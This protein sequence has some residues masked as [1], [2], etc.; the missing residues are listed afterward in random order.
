MK[1]IICA[2][3]GSCILFMTGCNDWLEVAPKNRLDEKEMFS[4]EAGFKNALTGIYIGLKNDKLYGKN[5]SMD[6]VEYLA[7]HWEASPESLSGYI[8]DYDYD[9][10][11]VARE[12]RA[13]YEKFY[14]VIVNINN[15][16]KYIDNGVLSPDM[17][18]LIKGEAL[19]LR[20]FCHLDLLRLFG[21]VPAE[22]TEAKILAYARIVSRENQLPNTW[23]EYVGFLVKD[24]NEAEALLKG[25]DMKGMED[26]FYSYRE[27]RMN[28]WAVLAL[29]ARYYM[30]VGDKKNAGKYAGLIIED[31]KFRLNSGQDFATGGKIAYPE[32]IFALH[33]YD[34]DERVTAYF[35]RAG[36]VHKNKE[37]VQKDIF[38][39]DIT[40]FRLTYLW[41]EIE[42]QSKTRYVLTKYR[43]EGAAS[44]GLQQIPLIRLYEMYLIAIECADVG[45]VYKP[46][47]DALVVAR[48]MAAPVIDNTE[49][50][51]KF[52]AG[53]YRKEF[54][55]EGYEF[56]CYKRKGEYDILWADKKGSKE[57]YVLPLPKTE[58]K[59]Y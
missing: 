45:S 34:L 9:N 17:Y 54:Y 35:F 26:D 33:H 40:D 29:K 57:V 38:Q 43:Q 24:L 46:L 25:V 1:K 22:K 49:K 37:K 48:N 12:I 55:G 13:M 15:L 2:I 41:E 30:W 28:Y 47:I 51:N 14:N 42:D 6:F 58:I 16:L 11:E 4:D 36:G 44:A 52:V 21:P 20:A 56:F 18:A 19:G 31:K 27:N 7:Q 3:V 50:K 53:E 39:S 10:E 32:F 5:L 23:D 8:G 59:F